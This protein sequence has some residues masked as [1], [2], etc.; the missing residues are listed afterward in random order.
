MFHLLFES[1]AAEALN[2]AMDLEQSIEGE[3]VVLQDDLSLGPIS[4]LET[5]EGRQVRTEWLAGVTG[6]DAKA[7][8]IAAQDAAAVQQVIDRM[9]GEEFD[10][11]WIWVAPNARDLTGY[12]SLM[13][14]LKPFSGRVFIVSLNNLPFINEKGAVFYPTSLAD[15][16]AREFVKARKLTRAVSTAEFETDPDEWTALASGGRS[17]RIWEGHR[18]LRQEDESF[19]DERIKKSIT[20]EWQKAG[21]IVH[22]FLAKTERMP[23]DSFIHWRLNEMQ[24]AGLLEKQGEGFRIAGSNAGP[25]PAVEM[26]ELA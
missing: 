25:A 26:G 9:T 4:D 18:K 15:I 7:G 8:S 22:Q 17:L 2:A 24:R 1:R 20:A 16:P 19:Y 21:R 13:P 11:I 10:Q 6:A 3:I 12:F 14:R 5:E 23:A